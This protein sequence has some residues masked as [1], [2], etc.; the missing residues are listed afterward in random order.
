MRSVERWA[1]WRGGG[2]ACDPP[3]SPTTRHHAPKKQKIQRTSAPAPVRLHMQ[4]KKNRL[5]CVLEV[6]WNF[7][8]LLKTLCHINRGTEEGS[9]VT[10]L[11]TNIRLVKLMTRIR[12]LSH[13][14]HMLLMKRST[15]VWM[16]CWDTVL[17][18]TRLIQSLS[19]MMVLLAVINVLQKCEA[20][21]HYAFATA[22]L[23]CLDFLSL[24]P[25]NPR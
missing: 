7:D 1:R 12:F 22:L 3:G 9:K 23:A 11:H 20:R 13:C 10:A 14:I 18:A 6:L 2:K 19:F 16:K 24:L 15:D 4:R 5:H 21:N 17:L 8:R 25:V